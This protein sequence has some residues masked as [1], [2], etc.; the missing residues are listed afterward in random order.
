[1]RLWLTTIK[2]K[3]FEKMLQHLL[4]SAFV[5]SPMHV[6]SAFSLVNWHCRKKKHKPINE[7]KEK[8][9]IATVPVN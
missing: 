8:G 4:C 3:C 1:M 2:N 7:I 5:L 9:T 6:Y